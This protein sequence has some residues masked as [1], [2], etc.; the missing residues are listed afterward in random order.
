MG[1]ELAF[2]IMNVN[3]LLLCGMFPGMKLVAQ[4]PLLSVQSLMFAFSFLFGGKN[5]IEGSSCC[6][7]TEELIRLGKGVE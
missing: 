3:F 5:G 7:V 4:L 6:W 2:C 1:S